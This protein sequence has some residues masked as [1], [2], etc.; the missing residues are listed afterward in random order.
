M[1][2]QQ[3]IPYCL[4]E[5]GPQDV[6][7]VGNYALCIESATGAQPAAILYF[8]DSNRYAE[9]DVGGY[10]WIRAIK[11]NGIETRR[12]LGVDSVVKTRCRLVHFSTFL[13]PNTMRCGMNIFAKAS[14]MKTYAVHGSTLAFLRQ[15]TLPAT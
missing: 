4:S 13:C 6:S 9:T 12:V 8:L 14:S 11:S 3:S 5:P 7:G 2:V 1:A 15:R 10:G